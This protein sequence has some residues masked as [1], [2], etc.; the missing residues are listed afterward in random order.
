MEVLQLS[1]GEVNKKT[2]Q[3]LSLDSEL[4]NQQ[5]ILASNLQFSHEIKCDHSQKLIDELIK[6]MSYFRTYDSFIEELNKVE[7]AIDK[8]GVLS[9]FAYTISELKEEAG[10]YKFADEIDEEHRRL[11]DKQC[12]C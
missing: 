8:K 4:S 9:D 3:I 12:Y 1:E 10:R 7:R 11:F 6:N 2:K 5:A